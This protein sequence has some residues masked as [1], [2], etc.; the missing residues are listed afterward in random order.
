M[1]LLALSACQSEPQ[2]ITDEPATKD[3]FLGQERPELTAIP[4]APGVR[5][6]QGWTLGGDFGPH[7][8]EFYLVNPD[9]GGYAAQVIVFKKEGR[10]WTQHPF[11]Q[12]HS[13]DSNRLY[14]RNKYIE[15]TETG[16]ST[17]K[18][19]DP[20]LER[21]DWGIMR[22]TASQKGTYVFDD[23]KSNDVIR[24][25]RI[26]DGV[27]EEPQL[28]GP[29]INVGEWTAHPVI[30]P[31]ESYLIWDSEREDGHGASDI[32]VTF[33]QPDG[34][35]GKAINLGDQVNSAQDDF[36]SW[37]TP[38]GK[39][40]FFWRSE[41]KTNPDGSTYQDSNRYWVSTQVIENLRPQ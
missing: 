33:R 3:P 30:A 13:T 26:K 21:E 32:Y 34:E 17:M 4:F 18:S 27:R 7:S 35:W 1:G 15:R 31:D 16:W 22:V 24:I 23:Y 40:L 39:Y 20:L 36:S 38:D 10:T 9:Q 25:S 14:R 28:L 12:T 2:G 11:L 41:E 29:E 37:I 19:I 8:E 5:Y 6:T